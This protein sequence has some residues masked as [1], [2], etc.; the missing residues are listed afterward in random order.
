MGNGEMA[1]KEFLSARGQIHEHMNILSL[2][3]CMGR[4]SFLKKL[5][6]EKAIFSGQ[7]Y[8]GVFN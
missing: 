7:I 5:F 2:S 8:G 4:D 1:S 3:K 6:I